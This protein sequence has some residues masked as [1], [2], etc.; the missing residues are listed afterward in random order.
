MRYRDEVIARVCH[1]ANR[2][3]QAIQQVPGIPVA[4]PWAGFPVRE[5]QGVI[6]GVRNAVSGATPRQLHEEWRLAKIADG[7]MPGLRKDADAKTH[8]CLVPYDQLS[9]EQQVKDI[10][11]TA[12]VRALTGQTD[13]GGQAETPALPRRLPVAGREP[14][15]SDVVHYVSE[16][17]PFRADGTQ[18]YKSECRAAIVTE[19]RAESGAD[20]VGLFVANPTGTFH[21]RD[22]PFDPGT[23]AGP[24]REH[25]GAGPLPLITCADL[26]F[27]GGT[28]H[29]PVRS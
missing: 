23:Y 6:D 7:W 14:A 29:W 5:Q 25:S 9:Y 24:P 4:P 19:M 16:G 11:F 2:A 26:D 15:I 27:P 28:W 10:L 3:L 12:I 17:S 13:I 8:P 22:I 1:E 20:M 18:K 21:N